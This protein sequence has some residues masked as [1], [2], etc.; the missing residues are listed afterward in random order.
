MYNCACSYH[1]SVIILQEKIDD[2]PA[3]II[4]ILGSFVKLLPN[5][6]LVRENFPVK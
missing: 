2:R 3:I 6:T 5:I 1:N 4:I